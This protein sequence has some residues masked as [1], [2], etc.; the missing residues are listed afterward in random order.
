MNYKEEAREI[1]EEY[2]SS[3]SEVDVERL[4]RKLE[5]ITRRANREK[6]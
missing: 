1:L 4:A 6:V 5:E 2:A 3:Y